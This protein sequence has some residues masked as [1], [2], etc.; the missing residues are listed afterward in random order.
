MPAEAQAGARR[1]AQP[2]PLIFLVFGSLIQLT[3]PFLSRPVVAEV[4][5]MP[6]ACKPSANTI[7]L[8]SPGVEFSSAVIG[9]V[10]VAADTKARHRRRTQRSV[11]GCLTTHIMLIG[12]STGVGLIPS[13]GRPVRSL[14]RQRN[15]DIASM[16]IH[17]LP[18][19]RRR[20][21]DWAYHSGHE[22][23]FDGRIGAME[24]TE[25]GKSAR[26]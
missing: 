9:I 17:T 20:R 22:E 18:K 8:I 6:S 11:S 26:R 16:S 13:L 2:R 1:A 10:L 24:R 5:E 19:R 21:Y 14:A 4:R 3:W 12:L 25:L 23:T 7:K 15:G